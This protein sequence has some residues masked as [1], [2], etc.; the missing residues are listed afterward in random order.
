MV[1]LLK[2]KRVILLLGQYLLD[3]IL[4]FIPSNSVPHVKAMMF[5][6]RFHSGLF[7][8]SPTA[9]HHGGFL[10]EFLHF[11][12]FSFRDVVLKNL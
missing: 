3:N 5:L 10:S 12:L 4:S 1:F 7:G 8:G 2:F 6:P 11:T 9:S